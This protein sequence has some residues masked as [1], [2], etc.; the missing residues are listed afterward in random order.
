MSPWVLVFCPCKIHEILPSGVKP[1][2]AALKK[3]SLRI[4]PLHVGL[5]GV[6]DPLKFHNIFLLFSA[7]SLMAL[8]KKGAS[9]DFIHTLLKDSLRRW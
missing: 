5:A 8:A 6:L 1:Y 4:K 9:P 7:I 3:S 2:N